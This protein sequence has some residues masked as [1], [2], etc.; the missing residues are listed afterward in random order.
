[1]SSKKKKG[2]C[3]S[4]SV[5]IGKEKKSTNSLLKTL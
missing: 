5:S 1:M 2:S 4:D 3:N